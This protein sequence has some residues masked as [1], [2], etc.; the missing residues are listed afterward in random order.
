[1]PNVVSNV[2]LQ[3]P[4]Y[5]EENII[6]QINESTSKPSYASVMLGNIKHMS[7]K[8]HYLG[9][10]FSYIYNFKVIIA[11]SNLVNIKIST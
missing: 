3:D 8:D 4:D 6:S 1:M 2:F 5:V 10:F 7:K 9:K 11:Y